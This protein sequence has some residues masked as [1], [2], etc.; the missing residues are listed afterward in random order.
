[1]TKTLDTLV[2]LNQFD[3]DER[4]R[5]LKVVQEEEDRLK[6]RI[7]D[8]DARIEQ[9]KATAKAQPEYGDAYVRFLNWA[10]SEKARTHHKI[11]ALQPLLEHARDKLA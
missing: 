8:L 2:R 4:R 5:E 3:V 1:M 9:E 10:R 6:A 11:A 7:A